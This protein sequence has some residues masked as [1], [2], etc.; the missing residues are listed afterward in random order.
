[1]QKLM[2]ASI[3]FDDAPQLSAQQIIARAKR[4]HAKKRLRLVVI[5]HLHEMA[6]PGK[7]GR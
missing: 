4:A 7:Q 1:M 5:D 6:L 3:V 2:D